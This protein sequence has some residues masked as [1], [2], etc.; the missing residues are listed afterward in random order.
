MSDHLLL[1]SENTT[2]KQQSRAGIWTFI[3]VIAVF[4]A[5]CGRAPTVTELQRVRSGAL[6][7]V[8]LSPHGAL[9]HGK[10]AFVI[11]FRSASGASLVDVGNVRGSANM[12]M[13]GTPMVA[14]IEVKRTEVA[15]RYEANGSFDMA[16]TW[17]MTIQW[18]G[19][20][21]QGSVTFPGTVQ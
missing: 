7:I 6:D 2:M 17:R 12:P 20:A 5:A 15:G 10:D 8:L 14:G 13:P 19:P 21:G 18:E 1:C 16:G 11:E 3:V 9:H 4:A